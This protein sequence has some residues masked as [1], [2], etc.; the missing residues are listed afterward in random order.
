MAVRIIADKCKG[1]QKCLKNCPFDAITMQGKIADIGPACTNCGNC[2]E[3]CPFDAIEKVDD[4][5]KG[6][7]VTL[8]HDVWVFAEQRE[9]ALWALLS[10]FSAKVVS[11]LTRSAASS[12]Q[13][14]A[15]TT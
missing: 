14:S 13:F 10:S 3:N 1:C 15:A 7:D 8:Y 11:L 5:N 9:G 12:A 6:V 2:L 4:G